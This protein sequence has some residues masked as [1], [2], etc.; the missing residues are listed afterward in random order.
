MRLRRRTWLQAVG[1]GAAGL[2][3]GH[4]SG[5]EEIPF[6]FPEGELDGASLKYRNGVPVLTVAGSPER[7]GRQVAKLAAVPAAR[8]LKY[9]KEAL[10]YWSV[11]FLWPSFVK[12]GEQLL[13]RFPSDQRREWQALV[14]ASGQDRELLLAGNTLF[15]IKKFFGCSAVGIEPA[16]SRSG[17]PLLGRNLDFETL[18][19]L[20][21]YTLVT[22]CRP[23]DKLAWAGVGFPG[24]V[25]C[26]SGM[27][28]AGLCIAMLECYD[29]AESTAKFSAEGVPYALCIRRMLE[30]CRTIDEARRLLESLPRTTLYGLAVCDRTRTA[31]LEVTPKRVE[32]RKPSEG[33]AL[34]TNHF[35]AEGLRCDDKCWRHDRLLKLREVPV[36][37]REHVAAAL[38]SVHQGRMTL[39]TMVFDPAELD[40]HLAFGA[41]PSTHLPLQTVR[42]K[43]DL[44]G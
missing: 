26:L 42:L 1:L 39:Q 31:V 5:A 17:S 38:R 36:I 7:I 44:L 13:E 25:G 18:G 34:A 19:Y 32:L 37:D 23:T 21:R 33:L 9:P 6:R 28:E 16:R 8:L 41:C 3:G 27:N 2:W 14:E 43:R 22:V 29:C 20:H 40:L 10:R 30:E 11:E 15:D 4:A 35:R 24:M 12:I